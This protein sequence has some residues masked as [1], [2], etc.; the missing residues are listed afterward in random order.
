MRNGAVYLIQNKRNPFI[1]HPEFAAMI[2]DSANVTAVGDGPAGPTIVLLQ[3]SPNPFSAHTTINFVLPQRERVSLGVFDV[4]GRLVRA[5]ESSRP[6]EAGRHQSSWDGR[7]QQGA[8][9]EAGL[10]FYRFD[11]G[12]MSATRRMVLTR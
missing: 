8:P 10:Y 7:N 5:L 6:M 1:D 9:V 12:T 4:A 11:A 3:N 2:W